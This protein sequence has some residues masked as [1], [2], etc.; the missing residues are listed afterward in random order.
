METESRLSRHALAMADHLVVVQVPALWGRTP[1]QVT[2]LEYLSWM[3]VPHAGADIEYRLPDDVCQELATGE[4]QLLN[5]LQ[6]QLE[7]SGLDPDLAHAAAKIG[8]VATRLVADD[9]SDVQRL[10]IQ[11]MQDVLQT[12]WSPSVQLPDVEG[13][14]DFEKWLV[15]IGWVDADISHSELLRL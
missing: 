11:T 3:C 2:E 13:L 15:S 10:L 12:D 9:R 14:S 7:D 8:V 5:D 1:P 4:R 6:I